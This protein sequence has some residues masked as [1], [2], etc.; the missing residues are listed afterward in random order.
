MHPPTETDC[1]LCLLCLCSIANPHLS[2]MALP[3]WLQHLFLHIVALFFAIYCS[4]YSYCWAILK[5]FSFFSSYNGSS[6]FSLM[7]PPVCLW[8][9]RVIKRL[10]CNTFFF[11][12]ITEL[13]VFF[14]L[15]CFVYLY[16]PSVWETR[17]TKDKVL[18]VYV[19]KTL[20]YMFLNGGM[21]FVWSFST[22]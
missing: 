21:T 14:L 7:P 8:Y 9:Y 18:C 17:N 11:G 15:F 5:D 16:L 13:T 10:S 19:V 1:T 3:L 12:E 4:V 20:S 6:F 22:I 2:S